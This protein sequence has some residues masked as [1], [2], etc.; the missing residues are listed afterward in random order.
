MQSPS[1][2]SLCHIYRLFLQGLGLMS[3][4]LHTIFSV[5]THLI[6]LKQKYCKHTYFGDFFFDTYDGQFSLSVNFCQ[7]YRVIYN[8]QKWTI[9]E[10]PFSKKSNFPRQCN[11]QIF[12]D[13]RI[14]QYLFWKLRVAVWLI[15]GCQDS[16]C[17]SSEV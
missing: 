2:D 13:I 9:L 5:N 7:T 3:L 6:V 15:L 4:A 10:Y 8:T 1:Y 12:Y 17:Y 11:F 14:N 16:N